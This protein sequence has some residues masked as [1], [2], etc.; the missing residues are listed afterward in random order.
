M[1]S[2]ITIVKMNESHI[3]ALADIEKECFS[4]PWS[5]DALK[6]ELHNPGAIFLVAVIGSIVIGYVGM[7]YVLDEGYITNIAITREYRKNGA[8]KTL[9]KELFL[10]CEKLRLSF[11]SL[12]VRVSNYIAINLYDKLGFENVGLR[13]KFYKNPNEDAF[14]MTKYFDNVKMEGNV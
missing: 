1:V 5:I 6:E 9:L 10:E 2:N 7:Q 13:K 3:K 8:A 11:L 12:E 14:I 4:S